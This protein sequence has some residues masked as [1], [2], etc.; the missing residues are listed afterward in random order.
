MFKLKRSTFWIFLGIIALVSPFIIQVVMTTLF[1]DIPGGSNDGWLGFWGGYLGA[2]ISIAGV[3]RSIKAQHEDNEIGRVQNNRP[4][5][6]S[7]DQNGIHINDSV[8][9]STASIDFTRFSGTFFRLENV[10]TKPAIDIIFALFEAETNEITDMIWVPSLTQ[11]PVLV[12]YR[13]PPEK[14]RRG[15]VQIAYKSISGE[16]GVFEQIFANDYSL[17]FPV[18]IWGIDAEKIYKDLNRRY[19]NHN[20][21]YKDKPLKVWHQNL[22]IFSKKDVEYYEKVQKQILKKKYPELFNE[23]DGRKK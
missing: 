4:F 22:S 15:K 6:Q 17:N 21:K 13:V 23:G 20:Q 10:S 1:N 16:Y 2:I 12:S 7:I 14:Y 18:T 8:Y 11:K 5:L 9:H 3:Y 19:N